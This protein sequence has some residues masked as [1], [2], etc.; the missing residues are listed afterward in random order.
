MVCKAFVA[1]PITRCEIAYVHISSYLSLFFCE[2]PLTQP[3]GSVHVP[4]FLEYL[5]EIL[6]LLFRY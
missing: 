6:E 2:S 4:D 1:H 5:Q 3:R